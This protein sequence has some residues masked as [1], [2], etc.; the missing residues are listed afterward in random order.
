MASPATSTDLQNRS[1]RTLTAQ[2]LAVGAVLLEDAWT[3]LC[4]QV[5]SLEA[6][7]DAVPADVKLKALVVQ[8]QCAMVMRVLN[9]P[10]GKFKEQIDDYSYQLDSAV[11]TG[12]L[13]ASDAELALLKAGDSASDTAFTIRPSGAGR[14]PGYWSDTTTWVPIV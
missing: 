2:E 7:L 14:G 9:N 10:D 3:V 8:I 12:A 5:P 4:S 6:R 11:S 13:Y 1:L